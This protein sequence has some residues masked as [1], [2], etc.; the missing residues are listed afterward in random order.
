VKA[1]TKP[2][3]APIF[4]AHSGRDWIDWTSIAG[5]KKDAQA[6]ALENVPQEH[7]SQFLANVR[8]AKVTI[9]EQ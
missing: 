4:K 8:F 1:K 5:T 9:T 3:W 7:E 6:K 2:L